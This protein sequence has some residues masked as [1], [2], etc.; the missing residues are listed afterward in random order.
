MPRSKPPRR[1]AGHTSHSRPTRG[2]AIARGIA[3]LSEVLSV[4]R[5]I[6]H[7]APGEQA[8]RIQQLNDAVEALRTGTCTEHMMGHLI[9]AANIAGFRLDD[10]DFSEA[11]N[12]V[13][14]AK[15]AIESLHE[16]WQANTRYIAH[17]HEIN[18]L[19]AFIEDYD[20][21]MRNSTPKEWNTAQRKLIA[22]YDQ[23]QRSGIE[24]ITAA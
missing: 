14:A 2:A 17:S 10:G 20:T 19:R 7:C 9:D 11:A 22:T 21:M 1:K 3:A 15:A 24:G 8:M 13:R 23:M 6:E 4:N 16:T 5:T 12:N 18:N